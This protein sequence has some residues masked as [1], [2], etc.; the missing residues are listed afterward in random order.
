[1]KDLLR[2]CRHIGATTDGWTSRSGIELLAVTL[3][4]FA[5][6]GVLMSAPCPLRRMEESHTGGYIAHI[7]SDVLTEMGVDDSKLVMLTND[8]AA[9]Q[10]RASRI[11][12][13]LHKVNA[14]EPGPEVLFP[15][16]V[17]QGC[18][19]HTLELSVGVFAS[20]GKKTREKIRERCA[21]VG[22]NGEEEE[23][24]ESDAELEVDAGDPSQHG[25]ARCLQR[26]KVLV[27][28]FSKS[29][30]AKDD[31]KRSQIFLKMD[32]K[33]IAQVCNGVSNFGFMKRAL[34]LVYMSAES[35]SYLLVPQFKCV[36]RDRRPDGGPNAVCTSLCST[37]RSR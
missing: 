29:T 31:L 12:R 26:V 28:H 33:A 2:N 7:L 8:N 14:G 20:Y 10:L 5:A 21:T 15:S 13:G 22:E 36:C 32:P 19:I 27:N 24:E 1:M 23:E 17:A 18:V 6:N 35:H 16:C 3:H 30:A 4:W 9:N 25:F 11:L 34:M 37:T